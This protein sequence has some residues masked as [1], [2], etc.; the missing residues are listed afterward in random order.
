M[1]YLRR[2]AK[3]FNKPEREGIAVTE[4]K[5]RIEGRPTGKTLERQAHR[6]KKLKHI[7]PV[8]EELMEKMER[9]IEALA[10]LEEKKQRPRRRLQ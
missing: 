7:T 10:G 6:G 3:R 9:K 4:Q 5:K 2:K 1:R 8:P